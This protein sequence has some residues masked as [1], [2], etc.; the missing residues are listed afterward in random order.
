M[1]LWHQRKDVFTAVA[2][3]LSLQRLPIAGTDRSS[4]VWGVA[5][6]KLISGKTAMIS[7]KRCSSHH[8]TG[9]L[10]V[11]LQVRKR[12]EGESLLSVHFSVYE[13]ERP[14]YCVCL[15]MWLFARMSRGGKG[16]Q[17]CAVSYHSCVFL[18]FCFWSK[19]TSTQKLDFPAGS[20]WTAGN[21]QN[22]T[23]QPLRL[24]NTMTLK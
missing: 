3:Q 10:R 1:T 5:L 2:V 17:G 13:Y 8:G 19:H 11:C 16:D 14:R 21:Y 4:I 6:R 18:L 9:S 20:V 24:L 23:L 7:D 15:C 12:G 22:S